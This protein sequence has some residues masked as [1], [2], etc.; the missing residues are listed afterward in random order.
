MVGGDDSTS[1]KKKK[2]TA[3]KLRVF[4][5]YERTLDYKS[6]NRSTGGGGGGGVGIILP[7]EEELDEF[8]GG[9]GDE[10]AEMAGQMRVWEGFIE[11]KIKKARK[12][13]L[14]RNVQGRGKPLPKD[15]AEGNPFISRNDFL[16]N[17][18]V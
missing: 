3:T 7:I 12:Q 5:A 18:L 6:G 1:R 15:E 4:S 2:E 10:G 9:G 8:G 14:F 16:I 11:E 17:R 13:G